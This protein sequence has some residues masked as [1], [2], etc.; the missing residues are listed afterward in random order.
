MRS[1]RVTRNV[2]FPLFILLMV[3]FGGLGAFVAFG[4]IAGDRTLNGSF[5]A[6]VAEAKPPKDVVVLACSPTTTTGVTGSIVTNSFSSSANAPSVPLAASCAQSLA[7]LLDDGFELAE[8][9]GGDFFT[10]E[11]R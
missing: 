11:R 3:F 5:F 7:D 8:D 6:Q 1:Y 10:L 9:G 2:L 4:S